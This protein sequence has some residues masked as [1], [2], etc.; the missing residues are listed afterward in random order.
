M[1]RESVWKVDLND[2]YITDNLLRLL[3]V[4]G[5]QPRISSGAW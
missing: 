4:R 5:F 1:F 3:T 2:D